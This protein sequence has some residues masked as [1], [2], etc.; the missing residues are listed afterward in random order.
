M[1]PQIQSLLDRFLAGETIQPLLLDDD[2]ACEI[3][4]SLTNQAIMHLDEL[5]SEVVS[6][7]YLFH[8]EEKTFKIETVREIVEKAAIRPSGDFQVFVLRDVEKLSL[9]AGNALL[10]TLEDVPD[11]TLFLLTTKTKE[12]LLETIRSRVLYF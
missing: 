7:V 3:I 10:K 1:L 12:N 6:G 9:S 11:R 8:T 2:S 4:R 5:A